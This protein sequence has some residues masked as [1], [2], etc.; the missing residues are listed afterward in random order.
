MSKKD[1][2]FQGT[3]KYSAN[4]LPRHNNYPQ[5]NDPDP[6]D[7]IWLL[8][9]VYIWRSVSKKRET[10]EIFRA[11]TYIQQMHYL[12]L[13]GD[14]YFPKENYPYPPNVIEKRNI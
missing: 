7:G 13:S 14:T 3:N 5:E 9:M 4:A 8:I 2:D 6:Q 10:F 11:K 1:Q 12:A